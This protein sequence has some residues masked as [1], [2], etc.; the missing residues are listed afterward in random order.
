[1]IKQI[2][3]KFLAMSKDLSSAAS[4]IYQNPKHM[5][6]TESKKENS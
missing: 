5:P 3:A 4:Y 2:A 6:D 1:M